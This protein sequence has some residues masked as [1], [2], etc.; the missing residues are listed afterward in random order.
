[1]KNDGTLIQVGLPDAGAKFPLEF[2]NIVLGQKKVEGSLIGSATEFDLMLKFAAEHDVAPIFETY[3]WEDFP[4]AWEKLEHG[5]P[6]YRGIVNV[7]DWSK[8]NNMF[9]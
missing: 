3:K 6:H 9:K 5:R 8:K 2:M 7:E 1:M 4:V